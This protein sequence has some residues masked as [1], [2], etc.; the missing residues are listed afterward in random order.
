VERNGSLRA[1][2][3]F[4]WGRRPFLARGTMPRRA[5]RIWL[6]VLLG[7]RNKAGWLGKSQLPDVRLQFRGVTA[8]EDPYALTRQELI[9]VLY[10][11][12]LRNLPSTKTPG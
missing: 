1:E 5:T 12:E 7:N 8:S 2:Q 11:V 3:R 4:F 9:E 10:A 6:H